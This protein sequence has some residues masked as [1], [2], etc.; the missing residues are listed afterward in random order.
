MERH[1]PVTSHFPSPRWQLKMAMVIRVSTPTAVRYSYDAT[2]P[3]C[4]QV[5]TRLSLTYALILHTNCEFPMKISGRPVAQSA[6]LL[7]LALWCPVHF[8]TVIFHYAM[9]DFGTVHDD[10][11]SCLLLISSV[12][13]LVPLL[14]YCLC[15]PCCSVGID[16]VIIEYCWL[17]P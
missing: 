17:L 12:D 6:E 14:N 1:R 8:S 4:R 9:F 3:T 2:L 16:I 5:R 15:V 7:Y 13:L 11:C 10:L